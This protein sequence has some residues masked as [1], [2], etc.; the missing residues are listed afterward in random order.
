MNRAKRKKGKIKAVEF[1]KMTF[2]EFNN[3]IDNDTEHKLHL[4]LDDCDWQIW[5]AT[6]ANKESCVSRFFFIETGENDASDFYEVV[7]IAKL[8]YSIVNDVQCE[9]QVFFDMFDD[10]DFC[11]QEINDDNAAIWWFKK[12][13]SCNDEKENNNV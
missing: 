1:D 4:V 13:E 5:K 11:G 8:E 2:E 12:L 10:Y 6:V 3:L 7:P 9:D